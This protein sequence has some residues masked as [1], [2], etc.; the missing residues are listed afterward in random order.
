MLFTSVAF[1]AED[2]ARVLGALPPN[3][4]KNLV[5]NHRLL[6]QEERR[7]GRQLARALWETAS[8]PA[9]CA[10]AA[11]S[12]ASSRGRRPLTTTTRA[13]TT[14]SSSGRPRRPRDPLRDLDGRQGGA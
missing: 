12:G 13:P 8:A 2:C 7:E 5:P 3:S 14:R 10:W 1:E 9:R 11:C 6:G 4:R